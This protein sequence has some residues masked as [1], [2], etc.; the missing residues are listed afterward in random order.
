MPLVQVPKVS[1]SRSLGA[2]VHRVRGVSLQSHEELHNDDIHVQKRL[3]LRPLKIY[4]WH[5]ISARQRSF[6]ASA[7]C[8]GSL[9]G[10]LVKALKHLLRQLHAVDETT[11]CQHRLLRPLKNTSSSDT[12]H[13]YCRACSI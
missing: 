5:R 7:E 4:P 12:D 10:L 11:H 13:F 6:L 3:A 9:R 2:I 8:Y 1:L